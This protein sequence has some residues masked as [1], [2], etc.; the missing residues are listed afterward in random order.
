MIFKNVMKDSFLY[1]C[2]SPNLDKSA[3][4]PFRFRGYEGFNDYDKLIKE[5]TKLQ[6]EDSEDSYAISD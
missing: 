3:D 2:I 5:D 1:N 4:L 6:K